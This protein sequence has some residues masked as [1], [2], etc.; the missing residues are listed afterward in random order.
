[1]HIKNTDSQFWPTWLVSRGA[2]GQH[3]ELWTLFALSGP[4]MII[5]LKLVSRVLMLKTIAQLSSCYS[6][7]A[8]GLALLNSAFFTLILSVVV[9]AYL[10]SKAELHWPWPPA[11][12]VPAGPRSAGTVHVCP[13]MT[14]GFVFLPGLTFW[15]VQRSVWPGAPTG[16]A[17]GVRKA[18]SRSVCWAEAW[19]PGHGNGRR[20]GKVSVIFTVGLYG[21]C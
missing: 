18:P 15:K 17:P 6:L 10:S 20:Y 1:M 9:V 14:C 13:L 5:K 21:S 16:G 3:L 8:W 4:H 19:R 11:G 2:G 7:L 12:P